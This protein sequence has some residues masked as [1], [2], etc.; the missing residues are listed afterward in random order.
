MAWRFA[1][2]PVRT[3]F[4]ITLG[5]P[6]VGLVLLIGKQVD[7][8]IKRRNVLGYISAQSRNIELLSSV[9]DELQRESAL[10]TGYLTGLGATEQRLTLQHTRSDRAIAALADPTLELDAAVASPGAFAGLEILRQRILDKRISAR[11]SQFAYRRMRSEVL[12]GLTSVAK[13]ALDPE[14]KDRL[15]SHLSLLQAK[16]SLAQLRS[17][18]T[19]AFHGEPFDRSD[20]GQV[21]EQLAQYE[22]N[23]RLFERG[24]PPDLLESYRTTF[25]GADVNLMRSILGTI[26]EKHDLSD[27]PLAAPEW[28][29]MSMGAMDKLKAVEVRSIALIN[30]NTAANLRDAETRLLIVLLSL[31]GVVGAVSVMAVVITRGIRS[32]V[33][34]VTRSASA[35]AL[36]DV[37]AQ[38]RVDSA[39]EIGQMARSFNRMSDHIRSLAGSAEAI[40]RGNYDTPIDTRGEQDTLGNALTRM[41]DNLRAARARDVEQ[42]QALQDEKVK[43]ERANDR[44]STLIKEIH[45]RVKNNLQVVASLL[46]LQSATLEDP[47]LKQAFEQSQS[48]VRSMALIH[49][50]LYKGDVFAKVDLATYLK[51]LFAELVQLNNVRDS[52]HYR[53]TIDPGLSV[54]L[55]TMVPLGLLLNELITNSFKHAFNEREGGRIELAIHAAGDHAYDLVYADDGTGI[56]AEKL[57]AGNST[58]GMSL[59]E[60]LV[61]QLNGHLAAEGGSTGTRYHIRFKAI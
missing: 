41:R 42:N 32:T 29:N 2:L 18:L 27:V 58:L 14:T 39:D 45:H 22:T 10:S 17:M 48:R 40:G 52:I 46:R 16:E 50:K 1:D 19:L 57:Q 11:D 30:A 43:L 35:L 25:E 55:N 31:L 36:G 13:L 51:E 49:E 8:S 59:I 56:P 23:M 6:V 38:V 54:D 37:T 3:K 47:G 12:D 60:S 28:W 33:N 26:Q 53:T 34:E 5:I 4:L 15:Y 20:V 21:N 44:I 7:G 24:A 9:L 61:E